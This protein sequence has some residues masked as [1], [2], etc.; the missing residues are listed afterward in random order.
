MEDLG[1]GVR[2]TNYY[3]PINKYDCELVHRR[4]SQKL[5]TADRL[6]GTCEGQPCRSHSMHLSHLVLA[7]QLR[8]SG[9][10][11]DFDYG[12]EF[13]TFVLMSVV[14]IGVSLYF[15]IAVITTIN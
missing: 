5:F 4:M 7:V 14:K 11:C 13:C 8:L 2:I 15:F 3:G 12:P 10:W 6:C 1:S 9:S